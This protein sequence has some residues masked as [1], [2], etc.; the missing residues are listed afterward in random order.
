M[1]NMENGSLTPEQKSTLGTA[2]HFLESATIYLGSVV[3]IADEVDKRMLEGMLE[4][5]EVCMK[6]LLRYFPELEP[7]AEEWKKRGGGQ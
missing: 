2:L 1:S 6:N 7:L 3:P 5:G 4:L